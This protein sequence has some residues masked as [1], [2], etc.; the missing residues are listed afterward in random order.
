MLIFLVMGFAKNYSV[1]N[2]DINE[3]DRVFVL[4][5]LFCA[6]MLTSTQLETMAFPRAT[7]TQI[8]YFPPISSVLAVLTMIRKLGA[9]S[10]Q[11]F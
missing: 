9:F 7:A 1:L 5:K 2:K 4:Q 3:E 8:L 10:V 11:V 6:S